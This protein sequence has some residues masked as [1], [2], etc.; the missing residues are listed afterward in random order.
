MHDGI[1]REDLLVRLKKI[2]GQVRGVS[3]MIEENRYCVDIL[4]QIAAV[5]SGMEKIGL[6]IMENHIKGCVTSAI[7]E[8]HGEAQIAELMD[9]L[10]KFMK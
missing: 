4:M 9:I 6:N 1:D 3:R 2:E 7:R 5:K 8:D 10:R